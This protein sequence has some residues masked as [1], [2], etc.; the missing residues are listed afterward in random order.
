[1]LGFLVSSRKK[2]IL[3]TLWLDTVIFELA[4]VEHSIDEFVSVFCCCWRWVQQERH[5]LQSMSTRSKCKL[6]GVV[7]RL[8]S[9]KYRE[10]NLFTQAG[11]PLGLFLTWRSET[12]SV[13]FRSRNAGW[14]FDVIQKRSSFLSRNAF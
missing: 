10:T 13:Y 11:Y 2:E 12:T 7:T 6:I 1:M 14:Y 4:V 3:G 9:T 5:Q 8:C